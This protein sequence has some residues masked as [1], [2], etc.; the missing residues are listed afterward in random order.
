MLELADR[1]ENKPKIQKWLLNTLNATRFD[2]LL[3]KCYCLYK[4]SF[5]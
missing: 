2:I 1:I 5:N 4:L 3:L